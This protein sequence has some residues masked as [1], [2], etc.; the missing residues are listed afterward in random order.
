MLLVILVMPVRDSAQWYQRWYKSYCTSVGTVLYRCCCSTLW[1]LIFV[2]T[3]LTAVALSPALE[4]SRG[5][6]GAGLVHRHRP[7]PP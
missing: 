4:S 5:A 2:L 3:D 7:P 1:A 6:G